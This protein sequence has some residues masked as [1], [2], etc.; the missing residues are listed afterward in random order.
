MSVLVLGGDNIVPIKVILGDLGVNNIKHWTARNKNSINK[1]SLPTGI[2]CLVMLTNF[3][4]HNTMY[5]FKKEAKKRNI[6][7]ICATRNE[8]S[9]SSEFNKKFGSNN[10]K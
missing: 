9:I 7:F 3:L 2:D 6:P 5:K 10:E 8:N 4:N 1:K